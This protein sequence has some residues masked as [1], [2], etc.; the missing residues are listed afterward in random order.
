MMKP[1]SVRYFDNVTVTFMISNW[2]ETSKYK[3]KKDMIRLLDISYIQFVKS[4]L[5]VHLH[6][7][8]N[9]L[10][11]EVFEGVT[12]EYCTTWSCTF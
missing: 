7:F 11:L 6:V 2:T 5:T 12:V 10:C 8:I 4:E 9:T 1:Q 3:M